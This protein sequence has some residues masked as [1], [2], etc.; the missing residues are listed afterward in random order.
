MTKFRNALRLAVI[1]IRYFVFTK[2]YKMNIDKTARISY[3]TKLDRTH[4]KG[5]FI[6]KESYFASGAIL[7]THD[8]SRGIKTNTYIGERC[9]IG[10]NAIIMAGVTIGN[11]VIVGSGS[12]VTK[13]V[14]S[15]SIVVGN[16]AKIIRTGIRT[17][18]FGKLI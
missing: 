4:P 9:F 15:N 16:P 12:I 5:V 2:V 18:R 7:F 13:D 17:E 11:E 10:A 14:P 8:F 3:G 6:G 1:S